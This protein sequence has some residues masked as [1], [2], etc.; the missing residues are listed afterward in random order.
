MIIYKFST[1]LSTNSTRQQQI[2][3][4]LIAEVYMAA[5]AKY[6]NL[7]FRWLFNIFSSH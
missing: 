4:V 3:I 5:K 7:H 1:N 2:S 6:Q